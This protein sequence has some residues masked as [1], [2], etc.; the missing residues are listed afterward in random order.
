MRLFSGFSRARQAEL[1]APSNVNDLASPS[2]VPMLADALR[3]MD[4]LGD[5]RAISDPS[6]RASPQPESRRSYARTRACR[7]Q[8]SADVSPDDRRQLR[9]YAKRRRITMSAA[10]REALALLFERERQ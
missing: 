2:F 5:S 4:G 7:V 9:T 1:H 10:V 8:I 6:P 3:A